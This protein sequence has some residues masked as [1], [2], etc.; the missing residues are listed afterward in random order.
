M[1]VFAHF[2]NP[3]QSRCPFGDFG[4]QLCRPAKLAIMFFAF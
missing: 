1:A 3:Q 2:Y 4:Y